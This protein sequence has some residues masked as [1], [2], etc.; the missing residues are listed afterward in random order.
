MYKTLFLLEIN[1]PM[2]RVLQFLFV[3]LKWRNF[4]QLI[5][6][7]LQKL[8]PC[9]TFQEIKNNWRWGANTQLGG[10]GNGEISA[11]FVTSQGAKPAGLKSA[12][13]KIQF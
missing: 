11:P 12:P 5:M 2:I 6:K 13:I 3:T 10:F 8:M 4:K 7:K 1:V 9:K